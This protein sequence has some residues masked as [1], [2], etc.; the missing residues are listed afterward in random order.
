M[1]LHDLPA[2]V[3]DPIDALM[4]FHRRIERQLASLGRLPA[5][6]EVRG[7]EPQAVADAGAILACFGAAAVQHHAA[8]ERELLPMLERR[9]GH[10]HGRRAFRALRQ[11]LEGDHRE[12]ERA[13]RCLRRPL[14]A[15]AEGMPRRLPVDEIGYFRALCSIH[16][17]AEEAAVHHLALRFLGAEDR[18]RLGE[19]L[20]ARRRRARAA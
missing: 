2:G 7:L 17:S 13:W 6:I 19:R 15:I 4:L 10:D 5:Q 16:I 9:I 18:A 11:Q 20:C 1:N 12:I 3:E 14:E 8:E